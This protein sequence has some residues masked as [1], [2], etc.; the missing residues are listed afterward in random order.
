M[1]TRHRRGRLHQGYSTR[2]Y[3][4]S[5]LFFPLVIQ[6]DLRYSYRTFPAAVFIELH[7]TYISLL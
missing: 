2:F 4:Y 7:D 6:N 5:D 1:I 3:L